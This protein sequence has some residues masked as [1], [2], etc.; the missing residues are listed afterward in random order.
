MTAELAVI[1]DPRSRDSVDVLLDTIWELP[2]YWS[3]SS[4]GVTIY[5]PNVRL[6]D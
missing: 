5:W 6:G 4:T 1:V 2:T 3:T